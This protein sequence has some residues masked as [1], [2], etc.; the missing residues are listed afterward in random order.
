MALESI[1]AKIRVQAEAEQANAL[2]RAQ[3]QLDQL[4]RQTFWMSASEPLPN[5]TAIMLVERILQVRIEENRAAA[6]DD[7][8]ERA[9]ERR[10]EVHRSRMLDVVEKI[11]EFVEQSV[12][13]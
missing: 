11:A 2:H 7:E 8:V 4:L 12:E 9:I 6:A 3:E 5:A 1:E 10:C 13:A